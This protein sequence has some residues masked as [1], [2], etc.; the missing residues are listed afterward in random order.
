MQATLRLGCSR[1]FTH[2]STGD[3]L[4]VSTKLL[5]WV[6]KINYRNAKPTQTLNILYFLQ[7]HSFQS[8]RYILPVK[9]V[10]PA[11]LNHALLSALETRTSQHIR[12]YRTVRA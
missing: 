4:I 12:Q 1:L 6:K 3:L 2:V 8:H 5:R 7:A 10:T 11:T 9:T